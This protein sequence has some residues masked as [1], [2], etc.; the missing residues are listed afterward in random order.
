MKLVRY[1]NESGNIQFGCQHEDG[2]ITVLAGDPF[3]EFSD[4]GIKARM[5]KLLSPVHPTDIFCIGLNYRRHAEEGN[6]PIP[7]YP[8]VFMKNTGSVQ[9]PGDPIRLPSHLKSE[10]VDYEC[11][12]AVILKRECYNVSKERAM[13]YVLGFTCANDVSA[14]DWQAKYGG[15]Q[16]CRGKT[17]ATFCP[18]GPCILT[19]DEVDSPIS[20]KIQTSI[21]GEIMQDWNTNDMIFDVPA[22][23]EFLS[24]STRLAPGTVILTGTPHGVGFARKPPRFLQAGDEVRVT[25]EGIGTLSNPVTIE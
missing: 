13:D 15:G 3:Q 25:I 6:F 16:W 5:V 21:N 18:L 9:H 22:L 2:T 11:E 23:I 4:T 7:D 1:K 19:P 20:L 14:R 24:G 8:I 10:A 17:F 12:L